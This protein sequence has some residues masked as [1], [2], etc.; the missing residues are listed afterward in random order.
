MLGTIARPRRRNISAPT[1]D[2][3]SD[4]AY[5]TSLGDVPTVIFDCNNAYYRI[6]SGAGLADAT[7]SG[8]M[9]FTELETVGG[10]RRMRVEAGN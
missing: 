1:P 3:G 7:T 8:L 4:A 6:D 5:T 2:G 9:G 10:V